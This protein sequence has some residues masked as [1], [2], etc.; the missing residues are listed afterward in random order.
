MPFWAQKTTRVTSGR[1]WG[2]WWDAGERETELG[3]CLALPPATATEEGG[4]REPEGDATGVEATGGIA[5]RGQAL[6][7]SSKSASRRRRG[8]LVGGR[9]NCLSARRRGGARSQPML[10]GCRKPSRRG[11]ATTSAGPPRAAALC[12]GRRVRLSAIAGPLASL[13]GRLDAARRRPRQRTCGTTTNPGCRRL[14]PLAGPRSRG[15]RPHTR[16]GEGGNPQ[17]HCNERL[18]AAAETS[19][20]PRPRQR[21]QRCGVGAGRVS[22]QDRRVAIV[23][24][25]WQRRRPW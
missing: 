21:P 12:A 17:D 4:G 23:R 20:Q 8:R 11:R 5:A 18:T 2:R 16:I 13:S 10:H 14:G 15:G 3:G 24:Q 1:G 7:L 19:Q 6:C 25:P 9:N 22:D